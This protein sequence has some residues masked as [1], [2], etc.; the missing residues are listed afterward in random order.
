MEPSQAVGVLLP[1]Y[2]GLRV[3]GGIK[4]DFDRDRGHHGY[5]YLD[6]VDIPEAYG[7]GL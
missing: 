3:R 5:E 7:F 1:G 4:L 6:A 2:R